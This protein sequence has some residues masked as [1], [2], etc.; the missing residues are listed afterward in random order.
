MAKGIRS[1]AFVLAA[2]VTLVV[3]AVVTMTPSRLEAA[4][5]HVPAPVDDPPDG[6]GAAGIPDPDTINADFEAD[7]G[8][9]QDDDIELEGP[10]ESRLLTNSSILIDTVIDY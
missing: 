6:D 2:S 5:L 4:N 9:R 7:P 3:G 8:V 10:D 1:S